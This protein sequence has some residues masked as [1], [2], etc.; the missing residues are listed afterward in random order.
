VISVHLGGGAAADEVKSLLSEVGGTD[1]VNSGRT[2]EVKV[3]DGAA[4]LLRTVRLLD[5]NGVPVEGIAVREPSLDDV[6]LQLTGRRATE[7]EEENS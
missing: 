2:I 6:F 4:A 3:T 1:L 7:E 5:N